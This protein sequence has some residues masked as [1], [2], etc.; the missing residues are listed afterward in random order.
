MGNKSDMV[1]EK[2]VQYS[3]GNAYAKEIGASFCE[4][5]AKENSGISELF[6]EIALQLSK[7]EQ[8]T[9]PRGFSII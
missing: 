7:R 4:T 3:S 8:P 2:E 1:D 5:S 6:S 9:D